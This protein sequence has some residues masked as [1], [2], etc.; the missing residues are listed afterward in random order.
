[1]DADGVSMLET[2]IAAASPTSD[3]APRGP[4]LAFQTNDSPVRALLNDNVSVA[5]GGIIGFIDPSEHRTL[6]S[7]QVMENA[8]RPKGQSMK[9]QWQRS[10]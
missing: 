6:A 9:R 1:M 8:E 7:R 4:N 3:I 10:R 2:D 5:P